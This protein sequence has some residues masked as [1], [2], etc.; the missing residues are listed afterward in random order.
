MFVDSPN[1]SLSSTFLATDLVIKTSICII[2]YFRFAFESTHV[3]ILD[4]S[5]TSIH[6]EIFSIPCAFKSFSINSNVSKLMLN[7][8]GDFKMLIGSTLNVSS[9]STFFFSPEKSPKNR[10]C[11]AKYW[12]TIAG[13]ICLKKNFARIR[14]AFYRLEGKFYLQFLA[15]KINR[16]NFLR[17]SCVNLSREIF[18]NFRINFDQWQKVFYRV[19][20]HIFN[21]LH[22]FDKLICKK[23]SSILFS[24]YFEL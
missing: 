23:I 19:W 21:Q 22:V 24:Q 15:E 3:F 20:T 18:Q 8:C 10:E 2:F 7:V 6:D 14:I 11:L 16:M 13:A 1:D 9:S 4:V 12:E 17:E 5:Q